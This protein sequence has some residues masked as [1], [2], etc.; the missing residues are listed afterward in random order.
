MATL[1][2]VGTAV[3][4]VGLLALF[5]CIWAA[6]VAKRAG[7]PDAAL[8]ARLQRIVTVNMAALLV[9]VIGLMCVVLGV[10]LG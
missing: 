7:L 3:A 8:R 9:S 6:I 1:V 4:L 10:F 5:Y 2:Y